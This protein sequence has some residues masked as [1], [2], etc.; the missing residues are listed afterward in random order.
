MSRAVVGKKLVPM[1]RVRN[2]SSNHEI[3]DTVQVVEQVADRLRRLAEAYGAW[4]E[5]DAGAYFDLT[6][7]QAQRLIRVTER[8]STVHVT[9]HTDLLLPTFRSA[10]DFWAGQ[11]SAAHATAYPH[12]N[13]HRRAA[14][15][16][17]FDDDFFIDT[18]PAML[19]RWDSLLAIVEEVRATLADDPGFMA[20]LA[21]QETQMR[22]RKL[23]SIAPADGLSERL[24]P[25]LLSVPTLTLSFDF[26]L[27][28]HRQP[29]RIRRLRLNRERRQRRH[30]R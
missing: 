25:S 26:P 18:Q 23:W 2:S 15:A 17:A 1:Y 5:F 16:L 11:F 13:R 10:V 21:T 14:V 28:A 29:G 9:F 8:V 3:Q 24:Q 22:W 6:E 30:G 27:P 12:H 7:R 4:Q 20:T 19:N